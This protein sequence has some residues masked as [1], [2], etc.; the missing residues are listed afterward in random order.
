MAFCAIATTLIRWR[1]RIL[2]LAGDD[3]LRAT[4]GANAR[5][6]VVAGFT[7]SAMVE[8]T[9]RAYLALGEANE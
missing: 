9:Y 2:Q 5:E 1:E 7:V 4:M 8:A 6:T 3:A